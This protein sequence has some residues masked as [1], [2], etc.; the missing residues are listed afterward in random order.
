MLCI[1]SDSTFDPKVKPSKVGSDEMQSI[2]QDVIRHTFIE[3]NRIKRRLKKPVPVKKLF[4][5][6]RMITVS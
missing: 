6:L 1:S 2:A 4:Y 5:V 3:A